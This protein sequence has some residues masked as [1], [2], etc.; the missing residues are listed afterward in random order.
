MFQVEGRHGRIVFAHKKYIFFLK[1]KHWLEVQN[2]EV[3]MDRAY[4]YF[5][6]YSHVDAGIPIPILKGSVALEGSGASVGPTVRILK[7]I[8]SDA[9]FNR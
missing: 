2:M 5:R 7:K 9:A 1:V 8:P 4:G 6:T 3:S